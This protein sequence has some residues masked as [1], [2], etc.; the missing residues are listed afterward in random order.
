MGPILH[1]YVARDKGKLSFVRVE[2]SEW[3]SK[4]K[5]FTNILY[6]FRSTPTRNVLHVNNLYVQLNRSRVSSTIP[7]TP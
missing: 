4:F 1:V 6:F 2:K 5:S 7:V 3:V